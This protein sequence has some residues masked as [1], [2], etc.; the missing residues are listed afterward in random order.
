MN[1]VVQFDGNDNKATNNEKPI[2]HWAEEDDS[3]NDS[4]YTPDGMCLTRTHTLPKSLPL[5]FPTAQDGSDAESDDDYSSQSPK[6]PVEITTVIPKR[7]A[8]DVEEEDSFDDATAL[9]KTR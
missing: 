7:K 3:D 5:T 1:P 9:K 2:N 6:T 4:D 8:S